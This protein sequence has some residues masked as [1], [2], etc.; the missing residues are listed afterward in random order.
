[1]IEETAV[2][3]AVAGLVGLAVGLEREWSGH[4]TGP[5]ARFA[6]VRTFMLLGLIGGLAGWSAAAGHLALAVPLVVGA[7]ALTIAAYVLAVRQSGS[8]DGT[9]E[10][11]ALAVISLGAMAG[12]GHLA[13]ASAVTAVMVLALREK[14]R[15]QALLPRILEPE[16]R[17]A[18]QFAVLAL[19]ILP[20]VPTGPFG[21]FG[22]IR[23]RTL[24]IVVLLLS[25][26]NFAG[27]IARRI[28]GETRGFGIAG[29]LGGIVSSTAVT[30]AFSQ[31][32]R[33]EPEH[34][35]ALG[36]GVLAA[37]TVLVPRV[38]AVSTALNPALGVALAPALALPLL[39]GAVVVYLL[40]RRRPEEEGETNHPPVEN[41]LQL[42]AAL[43]MAVLFQA[44]LLGLELARDLLGDTGLVGTA[45]LLGLTDMDALTFSMSRMA[46]ESVGIPLAAR[47][48]LVGLTANTVLKLV[49]SLTVGAGSFRR[50]TGVGLAALALATLGGFWLVGG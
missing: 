45:A 31:R 40:R 3:L 14:Q 39:L 26:L 9:T 50:V 1:M 24:W 32:S 18:F 4:A 19:V 21:P 23:P 25:G 41:P 2:R 30:F 17:A 27:Y 35:R 42:G 29:A 10:V 34:G 47:A 15:I 12:L 11:A 44:V 5:D 13:T 16:L 6:G 43:R 38:F 36:L 28:V 46:A 7:V 8:I 48:I 33:A 49:V 22:G 37:C 20:L